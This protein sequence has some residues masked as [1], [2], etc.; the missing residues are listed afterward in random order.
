MRTASSLRRPIYA[1]SF[2]RAIRNSRT[3]KITRITR[4]HHS[5]PGRSRRD[6]GAGAAKFAVCKDVEEGSLRCRHQRS[7][8][9]YKRMTERQ[10]IEQDEAVAVPPSRSPHCLSSILFT[11]SAWILLWMRSPKLY[12]PGQYMRHGSRRRHKP[13]RLGLTLTEVNSSLR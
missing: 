9:P 13:T 10:R 6:H 11:L 2:D 7:P 3:A 5:R 1:D 8:Q 4:Q 12:G